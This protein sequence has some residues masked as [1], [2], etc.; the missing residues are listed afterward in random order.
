MLYDGT[1]VKVATKK[2][3]RA[4]TYKAAVTKGEGVKTPDDQLMP[5]EIRSAFQTVFSARGK[6]IELT[7]T[8]KAGREVGS[9]TI[10]NSPF[11]RLYT[12][13]IG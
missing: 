7:L 13:A 10:S 5:W 9:A 1:V 2:L 8:D 11:D 4:E 12:L 3:S 6:E